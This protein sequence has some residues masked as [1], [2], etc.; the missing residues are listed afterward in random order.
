MRQKAQEDDHPTRI[1][2][3]LTIGDTIYPTPIPRTLSQN[4][5]AIEIYQICV[6]IH[7]FFHT[8]EEG[9]RSYRKNNRDKIKFDLAGEQFTF[10]D[11]WKDWENL[12]LS[13]K[14]SG[15]VSY[16][17]STYSNKLTESK[18][19]QGGWEFE[20]AIAEQIAE[21]F[22]AYMLN[23]QANPDGWTDFKTAAPRKWELMD[24]LCR[25]TVI[26]DGKNPTSPTHA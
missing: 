10:A 19:D 16:Y 1:L 13:T 18:R 23:I 9:S 24:K 5:R 20:Y 3:G 26:S 25:A 7:E 21:S 22:V 6:F 4:D 12:I 14:E 8:V 11:W 2:V 17:A 15:F